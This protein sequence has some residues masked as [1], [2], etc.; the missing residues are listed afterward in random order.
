MIGIPPLIATFPSSVNWRRCNFRSAMPKRRAHQPLIGDSAEGELPRRSWSVVPAE[1]TARTQVNGIIARRWLSGRSGQA[2]PVPS[3]HS[4][5]GGSL[6][7]RSGCS[8][9]RPAAAPACQ[10]LRRQRRIRGSGAGIRGSRRFHMRRSAAPAIG[11]MPYRAQRR[12][13]RIVELDIVATRR[14]PHRRQIVHPADA[15]AALDDVCRQ[16]ELTRPVRRQRNRGEVPSRGF[17]TDIELV[18]VDADTG[19][20]LLHPGDGATNLIG[21]HH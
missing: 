10:R 8:S 19:G 15:H 4:G 7:I 9:R 2:Q 21:Q 3:A 11:E 6:A 18:R 13:R 14:Q 20:V 16:A 17:T 5:C 12:D 1:Q